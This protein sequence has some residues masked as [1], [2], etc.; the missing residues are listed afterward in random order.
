MD[1]KCDTLLISVVQDMVCTLNPKKE[2]R[3]FLW[4][5]MSILDLNFHQNLVKKQESQVFFI[6]CQDFSHWKHGSSSLP[7]L[8]W[9]KYCRNSIPV[10]IYTQTK[11][12]QTPHD[13][14][15]MLS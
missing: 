13:V 6:S 5:V 1:S 15:Q 2:I 4:H 14:D 10:C 12:L 3:I 11:R 8:R 7:C 9:Q